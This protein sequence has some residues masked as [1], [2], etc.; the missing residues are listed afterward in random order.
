[1]IPTPSLGLPSI[2]G[3][4]SVQS[5][6]I[7]TNVVQPPNDTLRNVFNY[8]AGPQ[9]NG[10]LPND[11][12][13]SNSKRSIGASANVGDSSIGFNIGSTGLLIL[14]GLGLFILMR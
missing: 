4:P 6:A 12:V 1:M 11:I 8:L 10:G 2:G 7:T 9:A 13:G 5:A 3:G 14:G